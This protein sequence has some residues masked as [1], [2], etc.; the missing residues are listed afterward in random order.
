MGAV[1]LFLFFRGSGA[2]AAAG[3]GFLT[4][5]AWEP[6]SRN[7]GIA[8]VLVGTLLI[9]AVA[10]TFAMPL[11][12]GVA[13]YIC[14]YAPRVLR[15]RLI[16]MVDLMAAV[17][18]VVYGLWGFYLLNEQIIPLS[19]WISSTFGWIPV[20]A[21]RDANP[22]DPLESATIYE[23]STFVAGIVVPLIIMP[24]IC[25]VMRESFAQTPGRGGI[26]RRLCRSRF[27]CSRW[28]SSPCS[29]PVPLRRTLSRS[30]AP[31]APS[32]GFRTACGFVLTVTSMLTEGN[33]S[34]TAMFTVVDQKT[35]SSSMPPR[36]GC[37]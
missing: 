5:Q 8:T 33:H 36:Y 32:W 4:T 26:S 13:L 30:A 1:G 2:V 12:T 18:G 34:L 19:R 16:N 14:E 28:V 6:D 20:L 27:W 25:S 23:S 15:R 10:V 11:A 9:A 17:P 37:P 35:F 31:T 24:T 29:R 21:I 7:F 22:D 3:L